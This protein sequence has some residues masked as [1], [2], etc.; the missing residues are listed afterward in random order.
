MGNKL[1]ALRLHMRQFL[2]VEMINKWITS[3]ENYDVLQSFMC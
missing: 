3:K 1:H 2:S